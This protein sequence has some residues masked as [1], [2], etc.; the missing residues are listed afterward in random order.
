MAKLDPLNTSRYWHASG[1]PGMDMLHADF[2]THEYAPHVHHSFVI[3]VTEV[4]GAEFKS[5]G[6]TGIA[7][8]QA[9]LVFNPSEPHSGRMG[10]STRWRYRALYLADPG[11]RHLMNTLG[12]DQTR[13]FG[14]NIFS[15]PEL[16]ASF[17]EL[18]RAFDGDSDQWDP[19]R[20]QELFVHSFGTLF[21]NHAQPGQRVLPVPAD[22][23]VLAPVL[24]L[25]RDAFAERLTLEQMASAADLTPFQLIG[26]FNRLIGL[27]PHMYLTQ[28]RLR[29]ALS[30]LTA[31][32]PLIEAAVASGFYDQSALTRHFKR[33]FGMTPLQYVRAR[34]N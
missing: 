19:L 7:Q 9:L 14:S 11:I 31:G 8:Q 29:A 32:R 4:G 17:L 1:I 22:R 26:A 33:T 28:L 34:I 6:R 16:I 12:I 24:E 20:Q 5:R 30:H 23:G 15:D 13:Y 10:G 25:L 2:T 27:T 18:H 21:Q 3:A